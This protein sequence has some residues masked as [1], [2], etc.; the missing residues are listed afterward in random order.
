M[1]KK[2]AFAGVGIALLASP[3]I[4]SADTL[5]DMQAQIQALLTQLSALQAKQIPAPQQ[6]IT[7]GPT[8]DY[9]TG[10]S[11]G[12]Y[13]PKLSIT[14]QKGSRD[15]STDGQV[16]E[17]QTFLT[18]YYN[19]DENVVVGGYFGKLT[20]K[21]VIEFQNQHGLPAF[22]IAGSLTR[23]KI[24]QVC[25]GGN[26]V[27]PLPTLYIATPV[28]GQTVVPD[29]SIRIEWGGT[30]LNASGLLLNIT[31]T[32]GNTERHLATNVLAEN[33]RV[34]VHIPAS[35]ALG[36]LADGPA[37]LTLWVTGVKDG[38]PRAISAKVPVF[39]S[40]PST[41]AGTLS[42]ST[43]ASSPSYQ[44]VAGGTTGV[45]LGVFK[46]RPTGE[47]YALQ[48]V[49]LQLTSGKPSDVSQVYLY[50]SSGVLRGTAVF[51]GNNT[52]AVSTLSN[53]I[54]L[55]K[56]TDN[57][58]LVKGDISGIG[59][60]QPGT[61][62]D[63]IAVNFGGAQGYGI[64]SG[65]TITGTGST[66]VAGV[67]IFKSYPTVA[68]VPLPN[69]G[70]ADGR[71]IR[72]SVTANS[73]GNISLGKLVFR[74][75]PSSGTALSAVD[76]YAY[77]DNNYSNPVSGS[78]PHL[79]GTSQ[80]GS[81]LMITPSNPVV[82]PAGV[83]YYFEL[84]A[85]FST[86]N[87]G[88]SFST[89]LLGDSANTVSIESGT[90]LRQKDVQF[91]W[92]P[93]TYTTSSIS[94]VDWTNGYGV[95][96]LPAYGI[97]QTRTGGAVMPTTGTYKGYLNGNL[98]IT[99]ENISEADALANCKL[100]ASNNPTKSIRCTW[101]DAEIYKVSATATSAAQTFRKI[102]TT[103]GTWTVPAGVTS[104]DYLVV[105]GGGGGGAEGGGGGGAGGMRTGT[106]S[107]TPGANLTVIVGGGGAG[108]TINSAKGVSGSNSV[109]DSITS[110][111]GGGGGSN[112]FGSEG[113]GADGG[114]GGGNGE[115]AGVAGPGAGTAGQGNNGGEAEDAQQYGAG[116][117]GGAGAAGGNGS[118]TNGGAGG[119]GTASSISGSSV[120]YAGGGGGGIN[121][122][123]GGTAGTGGGGV[124]GSPSVAAGVGTANTGGGGGGGALQGT[125]AGGAG[126]SGIVIVSYQ[127]STVAANSSNI[128]LANALSAL[129]SAL[130]ALF[131][132]IGQR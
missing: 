91:V 75:S 99:T 116:G 24:A 58:I 94:D 79:G 52:T 57:R 126:G 101:N 67:R 118:T 27:I 5:S 10:T 41:S 62:G 85:G 77:T 21:Y 124:G 34:T 128:N 100:N 2:I 1:F 9:G 8:D 18:D 122:A 25:G 120:T 72:F 53:P 81:V 97:S 64:S 115:N 45:T 74:L 15:A 84:R 12:N 36:T 89:T 88:A 109:F 119:N 108:A 55:N 31:L 13:C 6:I 93:N 28:S 65:S 102:F 121:K 47:D 35:D 48:K 127:S 103:S 61:P 50:D 95:Q 19:L 4:S 39:I 17:L 30:N 113:A 14:L 96:G 23:A 106:L 129:E 131:A 44:I 38:D 69:D 66:N 43:D 105:A 123:T 59:T 117:G 104:V 51:T 107:V 83:T 80:V 60:A 112:A 11:A 114:S 92:S 68:L 46:F 20:Q 78:S 86:L 110:L 90:I 63:L 42:V 3:L 16:S 73:A 54:S 82:I 22:G 29:S 71:L 125:I 111:G 49:T 32:S 98:F 33:G 56:D 70:L 87:A 40:D 76:L 26:T 37:T 130:R 7:T 132:K